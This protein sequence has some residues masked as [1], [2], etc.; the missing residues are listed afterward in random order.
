[1]ENIVDKLIEEYKNELGEFKTNETEITEVYESC[2]EKLTKEKQQIESQITSETSSL[3]SEVDVIENKRQ[4]L[5]ESL[6]LTHHKI[7]LVKGKYKEQLQEAEM[8]IILNEL[9]KQLVN[10]S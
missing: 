7:S 2:K 10:G 5:K 4:E 6:E 8:K 9:L 3:V 1:M